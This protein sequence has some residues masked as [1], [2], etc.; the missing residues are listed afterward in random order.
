MVVGADG[1]FFKLSDGRDLMDGIAGLWCCNEGRDSPRIAEAIQ[2][3]A[4]ELNPALAKRAFDPFPQAY[5][6]GL[7]IRTT[8]DTADH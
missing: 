6:K 2:K 1:M 8:G 7:L 3:Q 5:D 4:A